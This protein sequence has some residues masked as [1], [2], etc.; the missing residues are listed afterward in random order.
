MKI[1][2]PAPAPEFERAE[3]FILSELKEKLPPSLYYHN[4][5]HTEDVIQAAV[6]IAGLSGVAAGDI[7]LLR[8][9]AAYHD[10]GFIHVYKNHEVKSCEIASLCLPEFGF[11][12]DQLALICG[13]IMATK[14]PQKPVTF[15]EKIIGDADLDYLGRDDAGTI[16]QKLF[17][18]LQARDI[19]HEEEEWLRFQLEFLN[20]HQYHTGYARE[21]RA[22]AKQA[23]IGMLTEMLAR[24]Q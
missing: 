22:P 13:M 10:A 5:E 24:Y 23:Y 7:K 21:F 4:P 12:D 6:H 19:I 9:A 15:L 18:E 3:A 17:M 14:I 2:T 8:I 11:T 20:H 1:N 16:A